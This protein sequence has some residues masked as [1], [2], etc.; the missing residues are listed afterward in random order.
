MGKCC[1]KR[2]DEFA[3]TGYK[4]N[5][6]NFTSNLSNPKHN[7][8]SL[9]SR[10]TPDPNRAGV[11]KHTKSGIDIIRP[12]GLRNVGMCTNR[13]RKLKRKSKINHRIFIDISTVPS[14]HRRIVIALYN[15]NARE[16][17]DVSF[18]KGDRM[19]VLDDS[20]SDWW[21]VIVRSTHTCEL[22]SLTLIFSSMHS[23]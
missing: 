5:E 9:D 4:K 21:R 18:V 20:E 16:D 10:Y 2:P 7:S 23:I 1:S 19:E 15:Y 11:I 13:M 17:T 22:I 6:T 8:N 14:S 3:T 12:T